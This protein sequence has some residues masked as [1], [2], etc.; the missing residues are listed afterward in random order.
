[1]GEMTQYLDP[2]LD[3]LTS[4]IIGAAFAVSNTLGHGFL[5]IVYKNGLLEELL[6]QGLS[7]EKERPYP[8][9][10]RGKQIGHY[11]ADIVVE[12]CVI[13]ERYC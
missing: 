3:Q 5:E 9:F 7:V 13:V 8:V 2:R 11:S 6:A 10:Y 1:M 4:H 12:G